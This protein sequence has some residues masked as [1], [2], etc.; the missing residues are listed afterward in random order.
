M[1]H[2]WPYR[3]LFGIGP[4][5]PTRLALSRSLGRREVLQSYLACLTTLECSLLPYRFRHQV[6]SDWRSSASSPGSAPHR[7]DSD[8]ANGPLEM[9]NCF[10]PFTGDV[11]YTGLTISEALF[12]FAT[13]LCVNGRGSLWFP[14]TVTSPF[15]ASAGRL[16]RQ[17]TSL[18][19]VWYRC[20]AI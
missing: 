15:V 12:H 6:L 13:A 16:I 4:P 10:R 8:R 2:H 20:L 19:T 5:S 1:Q 3:T 18:E 7:P 11:L 9:D 17:P 14:C